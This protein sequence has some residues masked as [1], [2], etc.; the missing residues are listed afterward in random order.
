MRKYNV[1]SLFVVLIFA[2]NACDDMTGDGLMD[3]KTGSE[4]AYLADGISG[5]TVSDGSG[6]GDSSQVDIAAGQITAG[7]W[8]DLSNWTFWVNLG[9]NE[10]YKGMPEYWEYNISTRISSEIKT[11]SG[12]PVINE[13][14][15]LLDENDNVIWQTK[16][17]N[18][19]MAELW[20]GLSESAAAITEMKIKVAGTTINHIIK[21]SEGINE[22]VL[23]N[24]PNTITGSKIDIAFVV[25]ATGSMSDELEY[26]KVELVDVIDSVRETNADAVINT[27]SVFYRD[28]GDEY[29]TRQSPFTTDVLTTVNFIKAQSA[30]GGGDY[31]EA[32]HSALDKAVRNLQ[33]S[34]GVKSRLLFLLLDAPP[35]HES[36]VMREMNELVIAAA[37]KGIKIIPITAS[38]I[39]KE[40]EFLMRYMAIATNGTYVFI[41]NDSGIGG[42]HLEATVG[43]YEV[44]Y[45]NHLMVRLINKY[46]E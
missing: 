5:G 36:N 27:G 1:L 25:D 30:D 29:I 37:A 42:E 21:Y 3:D 14:V 4:S 32:V 13:T 15:Q 26:L 44:E 9:Q 8:N 40:T 46:L 39:D 12:N 11:A 34:S 22:I 7:E 10:D 6:N 43:E 38:G 16:T 2:F 45:L 19:G 20:P 35:H 18:L 23:N 28:E 17:D 33:W 24:Y 31:P 41:T